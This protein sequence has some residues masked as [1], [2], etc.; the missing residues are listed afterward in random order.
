[1]DAILPAGVTATQ[2]DSMP[3]W[4]IGPGHVGSLRRD[5]DAG[6]WHGVVFA[7]SGPAEWLQPCET[8]QAALDKLLAVVDF[9]LALDAIADRARPVVTCTGPADIDCPRM[10]YAGFDGDGRATYV[11]DY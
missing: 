5:R 2:A 4:W 10:V 11:R 6:D 1:M 8:A 7:G 3:V 9:R